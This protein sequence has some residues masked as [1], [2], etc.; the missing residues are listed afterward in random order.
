[1]KRGLFALIVAYVL[2]QFFRAFLPVLT[3]ALEVDIGARAADLSF[4]SGVWFIVFAAMQIP[5]GAALDSIG[6]RRTATGLFAFGAGGGALVFA[7]AQSPMHITV[8]MALIG[9]GCSP[10]LM[11]AFYILARGFPVAVFATLAGVIIGVGSLGNIAGSAPLAWAAT[12]FGWRTTMLALAVLV[13]GISMLLWFMIRDPEKIV[14]PQKG[15]V[16]DILKMPMLWPILAL[17]FVNYAPSAA[18]RGLW[19]GP[20]LAEV[21]LADAQTIGFI[22]L[23]MGIAMIVGNFVYGPMDR[24]FGTR[25]W[26]VFVGNFVALLALIGMCL[27]PF[28][29]IWLSTFGLA[30]VGLAGASFVVLI[31]HA[32][33]FF[34]AH[35]TGRGVTLMNLF[36]I[37]GVGLAQFATGPIYTYGTHHY[38]QA[39]DPYVLIFG[40]FAI[41]L[42]LG[43]LG[44]LFSRDR[45]D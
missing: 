33:A 5:V 12:T 29:S 27:A 6:P 34:P 7:M 28:Q 43:L 14:A 23:I 15:S 20:Y 3:K 10:V 44:Y 11:S 26:V 16:L 35:L 22:T 30:V 38:K 36:G 37:G 40:F 45:T 21:Y 24:I 25:K 19:A 18:I 1:M 32:K 13:F 4:A 31:A 9:I 39:H 17:M 41:I 2:S 42:A 8:A